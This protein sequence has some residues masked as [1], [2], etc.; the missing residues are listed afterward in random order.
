MIRYLSEITEKHIDTL[1]QAI[2]DTHP[3]Y[4]YDIMCAYSKLNKSQGIV[5]ASKTNIASDDGRKVLI[6]FV[7]KIVGS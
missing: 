3:E 5:F 6:K 4:D 2:H 1:S 7:E